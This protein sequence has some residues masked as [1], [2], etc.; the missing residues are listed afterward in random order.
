MLCSTLNIERH[1][2]EWSYF[3]ILAFTLNLL[4]W[5]SST[6]NLN[7]TIVLSYWLPE[8]IFLSRNPHP[9]HSCDSFVNHEPECERNI[10]LKCP[11]RKIDS[12]NSFFFLKDSS[13]RGDNIWS[14]SDNLEVCFIFLH[15]SWN[16]SINIYLLNW[17]EF[18]NA[19]VGNWLFWE[20]LF[21][22]LCF[23]NFFKCAIQSHPELL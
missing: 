10:A 11:R 14:C 15:L 13:K 3:G 5:W 7:L 18:K 6:V 1:Y 9:S 22:P 21:R 23:L 20:I 2:S 16:V 17:L 19:L 4:N 12:T 8:G